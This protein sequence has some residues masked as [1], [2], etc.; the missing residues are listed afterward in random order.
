MTPQKSQKIPKLFSCE[1]CHY[2]T[3]SKKDFSKHLLTQKHKK[4]Q[5]TYKY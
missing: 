2:N 3:C 5:N 1:N 4:G